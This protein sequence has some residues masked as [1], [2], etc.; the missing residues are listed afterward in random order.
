LGPVCR[1]EVFDPKRDFEANK[2]EIFNNFG[3]GSKL[4]T[5]DQK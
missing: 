2:R 5:E 4:K 3:I 1:S